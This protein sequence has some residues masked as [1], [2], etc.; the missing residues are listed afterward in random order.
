MDDYILLFLVANLRS[1]MLLAIT[2][3]K[4]SHILPPLLGLF[5]FFFNYLDLHKFEVLGMY[6]MN[7][8][9]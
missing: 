5:F 9:D 8:D 7:Y 2:L 3:R 6:V 1:T 4:V